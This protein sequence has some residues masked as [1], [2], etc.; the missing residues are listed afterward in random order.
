L[1]SSRSDSPV[2]QAS[3]AAEPA[4]QEW[5]R[6]LGD[7]TLEGFG[8]AW[9]AL[10]GA[11]CG[12]LRGVLVVRKAGAERFTPVA[13]FP[14][15]KPCG[16]F[17]ADVAERALAESRP[18]VVDEAD[19]RLGIAFPVSH[20]AQIAAV[21]AFECRPGAAP[22]S[23]LRELQWGTA[24]I[25]RRLARDAGAS[26]AGLQ[27]LQGAGMLSRVL[28]ASRFEDV[29]RAAATELAHAFA[30]ERVSVGYEED[31]VLRVV[32]LSHAAA[33][34]ARMAL[35]KAIEAALAETLRAGR[36]V[37]HPA[38]EAAPPQPALEAL[39][40]H[41]SPYV[42]CVPKAPVA[43]VMESRTAVS[44]DA[45]RALGPLIDAM[46]RALRLARDRD[47]TL[48]ERAWLALRAQVAGWMGPQ[49]HRR[50]IGGAIALLILGGLIFGKAEFR[51]AGDAAVEGSV[52][53]VLS[54]PFDGYVAASLARAG[55]TVKEGAPLAA[56]DD[57]DLRLE[58]VRAASQRAQYARQIQEAS[59]RHERG[60]TQI[61]QAQL[62]QVEAQLEL[63]DEQLGRA[64][65]TAPF[66]GLVVS[67]DL[68]QA[69]GAAVRK[70]DT[71]FEVAPLAK[72]R[73]VV[74]VDEGDIV[75]ITPGQKGALLLA[76]IT[77]ASFPIV[78]TSVTPVAR[79]KEG[80]NA[81]R[82]EATLEAGGE[83]LRPGMEG[84]AKIETGSRNIV[85]I[86]TH[87]FTNWLRLTLWSLWP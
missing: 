2:S 44:E 7:G 36:V 63:L 13:F 35:P 12:A 42:L 25:E 15:G 5:A 10:A 54:A 85:W 24:W 86:W 41:G 34:D 33:F 66:D 64:R 6:L 51:V 73:V 76:A 60:Q 19:G 8:A 67:G 61:I 81:F 22:D 83:R 50:R 74:Y 32:A 68:S 28:A 84:L 56:L 55:D 82:V 80:R 3:Q 18:V 77:E 23:V 11:R 27:S 16:T 17:L 79:V 69:I 21:A 62:A 9:L 52:R 29:A 26:P 70:G 40:T 47:R 87:R 45:Q 31:G 49:A 48:A 75:W 65:L 57:R 78:V 53:R 4:P 59:A 14:E 20:G 1:V 72:Y 71:L 39:A 30:F 58:R 37:G 46:S 38:P 43:F